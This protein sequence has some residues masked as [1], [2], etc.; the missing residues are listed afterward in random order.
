MRLSCNSSVELA[1]TAGQAMPGQHACQP[2][3]PVRQQRRRTH[4]PHARTESIGN[5]RARDA[6]GRAGRRARGRAARGRGI[7]RSAAQWCWRAYEPAP[8]ALRVPGRTLRL[9]VSRHQER[10]GTKARHGRPLFW[11]GGCGFGLAAIAG[12]VGIAL[13]SG[14]ALRAWTLLVSWLH[15][16]TRVPEA[17]G[18]ATRTHVSISVADSTRSC[19]TRR[20]S[21]A[22]PGHGDS[23]NPR[24]TA[25]GPQPTAPRPWAAAMPGQERRPRMTCCC[26]CST[27]WFWLVIHASLMQASAS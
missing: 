3:C 26:C 9:P 7:K 24:P 14:R 11:F 4:C 25:Y 12:I 21:G 15:D 27:R 22:R 6:R 17:V 8:C 18:Y 10:R 1:S 23:A 13:G 16:T 20:A 5:Q 19:Y 2:A